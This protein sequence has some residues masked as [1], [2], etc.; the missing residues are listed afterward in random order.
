MSK[1]TEEEVQYVDEV[2]STTFRVYM[3]DQKE[4]VP[5]IMEI[6]KELFG[7]DWALGVGGLGHAAAVYNIADAEYER[8]YPEDVARLKKSVEE[9]VDA[10]VEKY[11]VSA[12]T[13]SEVENDG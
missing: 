8:R 7:E 13:T 9:A 4:R 5:K 12:P 2:T 1:L 6:I 11:R 10:V 3:D